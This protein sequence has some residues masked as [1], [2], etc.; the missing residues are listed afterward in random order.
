M[1]KND[2]VNFRYSFRYLIDI[3]AQ[4]NS[5]LKELSDIEVPVLI[6]CGLKDRNVYPQVSEE[7]FK[8]LKTRNK[9]VKSLDCNHWFYDAIFYT[10]SE[11]Y[12]E[13]DRKRF[14]FTMVSWLAST[15]TSN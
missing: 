1:T 2:R 13:E 12:G 10:Q 3:V 15:K 11:E 9:T 6:L 4:R 7:F 14:V 5:N 8:L